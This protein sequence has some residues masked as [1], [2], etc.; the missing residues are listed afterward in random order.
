M[1]TLC[2]LLLYIIAGVSSYIAV[3]NELSPV[4]AGVQDT[5]VVVVVTTVLLQ[6]IPSCQA[7][8]VRDEG[9]AV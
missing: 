5:P 8:K 4:D 6:N 9:A 3:I 2:F 1:Y 7:N